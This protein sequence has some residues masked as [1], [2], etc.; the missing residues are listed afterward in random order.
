MMVPTNQGAQQAQTS[1]IVVDA[2]ERIIVAAVV[3]AHANDMAE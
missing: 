3:S 2:Q 1:Q